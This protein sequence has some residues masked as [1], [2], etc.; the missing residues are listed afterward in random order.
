MLQALH[1][2]RWIA[3]T[4]KR[5]FRR[6]LDQRVYDSLWNAK[7]VLAKYDKDHRA[8]DDSSFQQVILKADLF[9]GLMRP[10]AKSTNRKGS[11]GW[12]NSSAGRIE[13]DSRRHHLIALPEIA[14]VIELERRTLRGGYATIKRVRIER[15]P[16]IERH[17]EFAAKF[18][19]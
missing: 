11:I 9:I 8:S 17:W 14:N 6:F 5:G 3:E 15:A 1:L 4:E 16:G 13:E 18:S 19:H 12:W 10:F 7:N 2:P